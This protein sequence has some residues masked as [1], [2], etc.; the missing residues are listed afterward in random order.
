LIVFALATCARA[1]L[2]EAYYMQQVYYPVAETSWSDDIQGVDHDDNNWFFTSTRL[3]WKIPV[4]LDLRTVA[5]QSPGVLRQAIG[6][7]PQLLGYNHLGDPD[8]FRYAG[9][10]YLLVPIED[11]EATCTSGLPGAIAIFRCSDLSYVAHTPFPGQCNDAGWVAVD[12]QGNLVSSRQHIGGAPG[13]PPSTQGGLRF[14]AFDWNRLH[15]LQQASMTYTHSI[16][17]V[18]ESVV[19]LEL[20]TMQGGEYA[21]GDSLLYL[22]SGFYDDNDGL[23]EREGI[24]V[25]DTTTWQ[26]VQHST[27]GYGHFDYYYNPGF[28]TYEEPEGLTIWDLDDGRAPGIQGQL[29]VIV[30]DNDFDIGD[31]DDVDF[32]H[33]TRAIRVDRSSGVSCQTGSQ[34]CPFHAIPAAAAFAWSGAEVRIRAGSYPGPLTINKRI[35]ISADGGVVRIGQ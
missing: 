19:T 26:R 4:S 28:P 24:H 25:I 29:H 14:Y 22:V 35:R 5:V 33:Y 17:P 21:P 34:S 2:Y 13:S 18:N 8:V 30:I 16:Y 6:E 20:V 9:T 1:Q 3:I 10:D 12:S 15:T 27:R 7:Y 31:S 11:G 32:K 23:E